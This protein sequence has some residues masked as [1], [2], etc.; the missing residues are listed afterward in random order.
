M[1]GIDLSFICSGKLRIY[2]F[3]FDI[4]N[5]FIFLT[6]NFFFVV[7]FCGK[8]NVRVVSMKLN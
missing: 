7:E 4:V 1:E 5:D 3:S 2:E 6:M 8:F